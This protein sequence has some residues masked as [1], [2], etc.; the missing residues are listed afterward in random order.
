MEDETV[1]NLEK[2][3]RSPQG[4]VNKQDG[5]FRLQIHSGRVCGCWP[6]AARHKREDTLGADRLMHDA[7]TGVCVPSVLP[8]VPTGN[9]RLERRILGYY[10]V[11]G[12]QS[13]SQ[14]QSLPPVSQPLIFPSARFYQ[15]ICRMIMNWDQTR[16]NRHLESTSLLADP[17]HSKAA[18]SRGSLCCVTNR[19]HVRRIPASPTFP[20]SCC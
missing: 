12:C 4:A 19:R 13:G 15:K 7:Q 14:I 16:Y 5:R 20:N 11:Y 17:C 6:M 2:R 10:G 18:A 1:F 9:N 8:R 3:L